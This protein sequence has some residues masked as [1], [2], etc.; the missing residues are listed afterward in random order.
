MKSNLAES[1]PPDSWDLET[2]PLVSSLRSSDF[3]I[4][5]QPIVD[6]ENGEV[7]AL[8]ALT[9]CKIKE[10]SS[11]EKLFLKAAEQTACGSLG[12]KIRDVVFSQNV[13]ERLFINVHPDELSAPWLVRPDDPLSFYDNE[14]YL[15]ITETAIF[16]KDALHVPILNE[17][18]ERTGA[19]IVLDDFG[20]GYSN[21]ERLSDLH[22]AFVKLD[23]SL[24]RDLHL[25]QRKRVVVK[26][27][28]RMCGE[29]G[30]EVVVECIE[31]A[32]ELKAAIDLGARYGQGFFLAR[33]ELR[34]K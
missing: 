15:E 23:R 22:F 33:P 11:P 6:L 8:E 7:F 14:V 28:I 21:L 29:L 16:G 3:D 5:F 26:H 30:A 13:S 32:E 4:V 19:R 24:V 20:V 1:I 27:I 12:R 25:S 10:F 18:C 2:A 9:R 31:S 34:R 17:V